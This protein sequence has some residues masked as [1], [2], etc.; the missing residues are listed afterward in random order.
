MTVQPL[1]ALDLG[2]TKVACAIGLPRDGASGFELLGSAV[3]AYPVLSESWLSD[4]LMVSRTIEAA[5]EATAVSAD[6]HR[7]LVTIAPPALV[8]ERVQTSLHL[9]DEPIT[10]RAQDLL[11]LQER[12]VDQVVGVDREPLMVER[13]GCAG[14]GFTGVRDPRGLSATRLL[15][16]FHLVTMPVSARRAVVQAVES[17]GLEVAQLTLTMTAT[18]ASMAEEGVHQKRVLMIDVGGLTTDVALW[19]DG[20]L[21]AFAV[22]PW[23]G[24][25][26]AGALA[27]ALQVTMEQAATWS[28][29]GAACH[30]PEV[31][32]YLDEQW[33]LIERTIHGILEGQ[34]KPDLALLAG[35][36]ALID[37]FAEWVERTTG[38][39]T[40]LCRS[41]RT[42]RVGDL[43]RQVALSPAIGFLEQA[44]RDGQPTLAQP[45]HLLGRVVSRTRTILAEYF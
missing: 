37:G 2:S 21:Q 5:L 42:S 24:L 14:N 3:V 6:F 41:P 1:I 26:A 34:P 44:T 38:M 36:G 4:P 11:R 35:R 15:G 29:E 28:L 23:G 30:K 20:V 31:P 10:V 7:A 43:S 18:L 17:A 33:R 45:E 12:A 22:V 9:G 13:L 39:P 25:K 16:T 19:V 8:S 27:A 32:A 40:L